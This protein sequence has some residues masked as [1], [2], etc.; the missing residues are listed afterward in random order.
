M[1]KPGVPKT[2]Y[3]PKRESKPG[4]IIYRWDVMNHLIRH[5]DHKTY[6]EIGVCGHDLE[7]N[8]AGG[9][10]FKRII[11]LS[12]DGV[13]PAGPPANY[14]M[15]SD[16]FFER[17]DPNRKWDMIFIDG[18]HAPNQLDRD[19]INSLKHLAEG[20]TIV[21]HDAY[22]NLDLMVNRHMLGEARGYCW[23]Y[24]A[25]LRCTQPEFDVWT[26]IPDNGMSIIR[27]GNKVP[28]YDKVSMETAL[29]WEYCK[30]HMDEILNVI[31]PVQLKEI[32]H[33]G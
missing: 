24:P 10:N 4:E 8:A 25:K 28:L 11:A 18:E 23:R 17:L 21:I 9:E 7:G 22:P 15:P 26:L 5:F 13:D 1:K 16:D 12:K 2:S 33:N 27:Y 31:T 30:I 14:I 32:F 3:V 19:F 6:L 29:D 20:G